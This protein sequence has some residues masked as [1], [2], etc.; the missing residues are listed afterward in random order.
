M[1]KTDNE[2][3]GRLDRLIL[4]A[5][6]RG[7]GA[8]S[9]EEL[10]DLPR[11]Y[12][13]ASSLHARLTTHGT[14]AATLSRVSAA[15]G[16]AHALVYRGHGEAP[17]TL[18]ARLWQ[19]YFVDA[20]RALRAE[21]RLAGSLLVIF[22]GLALVSFL[23]VQS[24]LGLAF[25][26]FDPSATANEIAQLRELEPGEEFRGNFT[27]GLGKSPETAGWIMAHNIGVSLLFFAAALVPPLFLYILAQNGL[28][29]GTYTGVAA[30]WDQGLSISS[31]LWCHGTLELQAIVIAGLAGLILFR[32][33]IAPG[34]WS[35]SHAMLL[36]SRRAL[37]VL[38]PMVPMLII[39]GLIE[40]FISPHASLPVRLAVAVITG[41][42][43][44]YWLVAAGRERPATG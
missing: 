19:L 30:H 16:A 6:R 11:L 39:A 12:R 22:Y 4:R 31:I 5:R 34:V 40:G 20:P 25:T 32:A 36:E 14:E 42:G 10:R 43:F 15:V 21:W 3:L 44:V 24:D 29:L 9:G 8:L 28:M 27:F 26:L 23:A 1:Q 2:L 13:F 33:W 18:R 7:V 41:A 37:L 38:A 35:R 17:R